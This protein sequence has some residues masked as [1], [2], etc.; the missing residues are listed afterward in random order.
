[1]NNSFPTPVLQRSSSQPRPGISSRTWLRLGLA[2][3]LFALGLLSAIP[4]AADP[5]C[6]WSSDKSIR[7]DPASG[8]AAAILTPAV[9]DLTR[10]LGKP[11]KLG[12]DNISIA[13]QWAF[14]HAAILGADG[15][16]IDYTGTPFAEA[17]ANGGK[18]KKY[19][20][21]LQHTQQGWNLIDAAIGPTDAH[22][23]GW[24][25]KYGSPSVFWLCG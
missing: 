1:M 14:V 4:A 25:Q 12:Q 20:A 18:S 23:E 6:Q 2:A 8:D 21:L 22:D 9:N 15:N 11:A 3:P 16:P 24:P 10:Q 5:Q 19:M 7:L 13:G 17:A